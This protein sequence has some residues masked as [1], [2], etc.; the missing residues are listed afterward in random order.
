MPSTLSEIDKIKAESSDTAES[1]MTT[2]SEL[3][4]ISDDGITSPE[5]GSHNAS[6]TWPYRSDTYSNCRPF[7]YRHP[8]SP[9][10]QYPIEKH[11]GPMLIEESR[12][13]FCGVCGTCITL[14][15]EQNLMW[16]SNGYAAHGSSVPAQP[17][18]AGNR[19]FQKLQASHTDPD[20]YYADRR[21]F[22]IMP[23]VGWT[24][25][26]RVVICHSRL[27]PKRDMSQ[28]HVSGIGRYH[29]WDSDPEARKLRTKNGGYRDS[30]GFLNELVF[31]V[32]WKKDDLLVDRQHFYNKIISDDQKDTIKSKTLVRRVN[33]YPAHFSNNDSQH[34]YPHGF[35]IHAHCWSMAERV[36]GGDR[37]EKDL[38]LFIR[39]LQQ[40]W[41]DEN[42]I[43]DSILLNEW[44]I[45]SYPYFHSNEYDCDRRLVAIRDPI[46]V[47]EVEEIIA[48]SAKRYSML[49]E[50]QGDAPTIITVNH[51]LFAIPYEVWA[52]IFDCLHYT[53]LVKFLSVTRIQ[54]PQSYWWS[55]AP[56]DVVWELDDIDYETTPVDWQH[57]CLRTERLCD[58]SLGLVN[59]QRICNI[60]KEVGTKLA[61]FSD[62]EFAGDQTGES[63]PPA[64]PTTE[65]FVEASSV[66]HDLCYNGSDPEGELGLT[67]WDDEYAKKDYLA[68][69][70]W[71]GN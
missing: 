58:E 67:E 3:G 27:A 48:E 69:A 42:I 15:D 21:E 66:G 4:I 64:S 49:K 12:N 25:L 34:L 70:E 57:L 19:E 9:P 45:D 53:E 46:T 63:A 43:Q 11:A 16:T 44:I 8:L 56:R 40:R 50:K 17:D 28:Y 65:T 33:V 29:L 10:Y 47:Y 60:L 51:G 59:R 24:G 35:P 32:P 54:M 39:I 38:E 14:E 37:I 13:T 5:D 31:T 71:D 23:K 1:V 18:D 22:G 61:F 52:A 20:G 7:G 36:I 62:V 55:R 6:V 30:R 41:E 26:Y 2:D 68:A